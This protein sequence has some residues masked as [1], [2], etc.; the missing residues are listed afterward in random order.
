MLHSDVNVKL[1]SKMRSAIKSK[2]AL[3]GE[4]AGGANT[5]KLVQKFVFEELVS[6]LSP[7]KKPFKPEKGKMNVVMFVGLQGSG[8]TTT[9]T[10]YAYHYARKGWKVGLVCADTFRA[11]AFDQLKQNA[12]KAR[13]PFYGSHSE[14]DPVQIAQDGVETFRKDKYE[15]ILIDTSGRHKQESALFDEMMQVSDVVSP[16]DV[17]YIMDSHIGQACFDQ[18]KAFHEAVS[19]GSVIVTKLDGDAK[20][21]V[22]KLLGLGD[23]EGL[24]ERMQDAMPIEGQV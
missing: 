12:T 13:I 22:S 1:V 5:R 17:V 11:G 21:F 19:V 18:A 7:A 23:L 14:T 20:R 9:V 15:L 24:V 4:S 10:K 16:D 3:H 6:M 8:K 2:V